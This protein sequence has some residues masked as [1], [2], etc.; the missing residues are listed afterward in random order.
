MGLLERTSAHVDLDRW[1]GD[2]RAGN[3]R[4]VLIGGEAG[5]GKTSL[6]EEFGGRHR[7]LGSRLLW[8]A[9]DAL[10]TPRPLGPLYDVAP[11]LGGR[12]EALLAD[13]GRP[14][15]ERSE[16]GAARHEA[17]R[18][19]LFGSLLD[20]LG[21]EPGGSILVVEDLHWA[22]EPTLDLLRYLA[23]RV[24]RLPVLILATYRD[25]ELGP[26][27][28]LR[29]M[30]G[31]LATAA[32]TR[33]LRLDPLSRDAVAALVGASGV[34]P[35]HLYAT[36]GGN[37]FY[38]TE[39]I[40]AGG[41]EIPAT[42]RDAVLAR[43]A[44]LSAP[45]RRV[46]DAAAVITA[47]AETWL[48]AD[49]TG[50]AAEHLD[51]CVSVGIL[52][53]RSGGVGFHHELARLAVAGAVLPGHRTDLH[54]RTLAALL[55]HP[56][57]SHDATRLA[58]HAE[59]A[60]DTAAVLA[61]AVP[62]ARWA[63]AMG[64]HRAAADQY[65]RAVRA[66]AGLP[67]RELAELLEGHSYEC[68]LTSRTEEAAASRQRALAC[69][70][71]AGDPLRQGDALRWLSRLAWFRGDSA[72]A[73]RAAQEAVRLLERQ[74][75]GPELAMAYSNLA[76]LR[77]LA[78]DGPGTIRWGGPAIDLAERLGRTDILAHALN[79]VGS[80][81]IFTEPPA[82][83]AKLVRSLA[84]STAE[85][86]DEHA[87]R[88]LTNL[89]WA[90]VSAY[91][92]DEAQRWMSE[93]V[94]YCTER[95]LDPWRTSLLAVR[96]QLSLLRGRWAAAIRDAEEAVADPV[97]LP[98]IRIVGLVV[99]ARV[100]ARRGE[101]GVWPVLAEALAL[102]DATGELAPRR[103]P[104]VAA[105]AE[106]AWL[107][108][109]PDRARAVA[110]RTLASLPPGG[111][112]A[113]G[114]VAA[115]LA[116]W[117]GR[118]GL[119]AVAPPG[120]SGPYTLQVAG[121]WSAAAAAWRALD[122]PYEA[123]CA[124]AESSRDADLRAALVQLRRLEARP[125]AAVVSRR[126]REMGARGLTRGPYS[127]ARGN[128]ANLT[129]RELEVLVLLTEGLRNAEIAGR[130]F[131]SAKTV[132]HHVSAI[133]GKLGVRTRGEAVRAAARLRAEPA[134]A[135]RASM[136]AGPGKYGESSP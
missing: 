30:L 89:A 10:T 82:G 14:D 11:V 5:V 25:D 56:G 61:H 54:R 27:H 108:G 83:R 8:S 105:L 24:A 88:A 69:W 93:G 81:E 117:A 77:M 76:Q 135:L 130:L 133:L 84:L 63:A 48:L 13:R 7:E 29:L 103:V 131:I 31:H 109:D 113:G 110:A 96:A 26:A 55:G 41:R 92:L 112:G 3:G 16:R 36:T 51:E 65:A 50:C 79:N 124:L 78:G 134:V 73:E 125:A 9:C 127:A 71:A 116:Y 72:E 136:P 46:L 99:I 47:P 53:E 104:V 40:A 90:T 60:G 45:A 91:E 126:L 64:A 115:E 38:V 49:V 100:R 28:P 20:Q 120:A 118:L 22:D 59:G 122:C 119:P 111:D 80:V 74:P 15:G 121:D 70:Q 66:A 85:S 19:A 4:L 23:R 35:E 17:G 97:T 95:D 114:S 102:A 58:H 101:P 106:A 12:V 67:P 43:A 75:P 123:A 39:V 107:A 1:L 21:G 52:R 87:V 86:W 129:G 128:P 132:D 6:L 62:A 68:Y 98:I 34:D 44:R 37:P 57:S 2:A 42:V 33:R 32:T 94:A 18:E